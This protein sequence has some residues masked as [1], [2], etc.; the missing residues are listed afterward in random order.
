M[1]KMDEIVAFHYRGLCLANLGCFHNGRKWYPYLCHCATH[2]LL[3]GA[4][5]HG[6]Y[7]PIW[8]ATVS[9]FQSNILDFRITQYQ[10]NAH[11]PSCSVQLSLR[12][13]AVDDESFHKGSEVMAPIGSL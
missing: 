7:L 1:Q 9:C 4:F 12:N 11:K 8:S 13:I 10:W 6:D 5:K 2:S 3:V